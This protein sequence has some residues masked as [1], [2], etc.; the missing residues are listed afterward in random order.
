MREGELFEDGNYLRIYSILTRGSVNFI[1]LLTLMPKQVK[2]HQRETPRTVN[3]YK[4]P[5]AGI[6]AEGDKQDEKEEEI[7][8]KDKTQEK[9]SSLIKQKKK[10]K[11]NM[12]K[13]LETVFNHFKQCSNEDFLR[14]LHLYFAYTT[15]VT[16]VNINLK[17]IK[18]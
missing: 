13:S 10:R 14:Y 15:L 3:H 8:E 17:R 7:D 1:T 5:F 4:F 18:G 16:C 2:T 12:E 9:S 6:V 11:S